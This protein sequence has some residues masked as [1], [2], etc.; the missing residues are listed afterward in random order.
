MRSRSLA[1]LPLSCF[2]LASDPFPWMVSLAWLTLSLTYS[3][4]NDVVDCGL[5]I[6]FGLNF[7]LELEEAEL[8]VVLVEKKSR[9]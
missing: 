4:V 3:I 5:W 7:C 2:A 8:D 9:R 6:E 1:I